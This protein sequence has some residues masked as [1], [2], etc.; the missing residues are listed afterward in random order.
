MQRRR[1][2]V[3]G[4]VQGVG[5]RWSAQDEANRRG[6]TGWVA[7]CDDGTVEAEIEGDDAA[8]DGMLAWLRHGPRAAR[9]AGMDVTTQVPQGDDAFDVRR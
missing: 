3:H 6:V 5:F 8:V 9:V 1:V 4:R 7:N 2:I